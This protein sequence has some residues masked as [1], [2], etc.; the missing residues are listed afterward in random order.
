MIAGFAGMRA[1]LA[2][3]HG[4]HWAALV[5]AAV[6]SIVLLEMFARWR[7]GKD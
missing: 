1:H 5:A 6:V 2:W 7:C 4:R 3:S